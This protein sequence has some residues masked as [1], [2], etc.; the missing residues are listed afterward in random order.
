MYVYMILSNEG[1][2]HC[3]SSFEKLWDLVNKIPDI[4][5]F[6]NIDYKSLIKKKDILLFDKSSSGLYDWD[7]K[8]VRVKVE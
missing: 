8:L 4:M 5:I 3:Y 1:N 2:I 7:Y 6:D